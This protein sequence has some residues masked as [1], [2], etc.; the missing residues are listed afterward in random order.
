M[1]PK[2][3]LKG[4][5]I[6]AAKAIGE[7]ARIGSL[8]VGKQADF[9]LFSAASVDEWIYHPRPNCCKM[10]FKKGVRIF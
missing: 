8:E 9:A 7:D 1:T 4:V 3:V 6:L 10:T 5:T 2:E